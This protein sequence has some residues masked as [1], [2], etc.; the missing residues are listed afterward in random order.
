MKIH[1][2]FLTILLLIRSSTLAADK[3]IQ[4]AD[5]AKAGFK[6]VKSLGKLKDKDARTA[7]YRAYP[8]DT[9]MLERVL[10]GPINKQPLD[11][12]IA[13]E[14]PTLAEARRR[15]P[16]Y[17]PRIGRMLQISGVFERNGKKIYLRTQTQLYHVDEPH[18]VYRL[19]QLGLT[20][21]S[22]SL[23][24]TVD[25]VWFLNSLDGLRIVYLQR[26]ELH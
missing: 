26:I 10:L 14:A 12:C 18:I 1:L 11:E 8:A 2:T 17:Y 7:F 15:F 19:E 6:K 3:P 13:G 5:L 16:Q 24:A 23:K 9:E 4:Y 20:G 21:K 22:A 25:A